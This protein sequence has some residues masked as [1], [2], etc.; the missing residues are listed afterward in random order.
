MEQDVSEES[1]SGPGQ[2]SPRA[3]VAH[4]KPQQQPHQQPPHPQHTECISL[5]GTE[6]NNNSSPCSRETAGVTGLDAVN[7]KRSHEQVIQNDLGL[8]PCADDLA[9]N[10]QRDSNASSSSSSVP[11][12]ASCLPASAEAASATTPTPA[13]LE[14]GLNRNQPSSFSDGTPA[15]EIAMPDV[16]RRPAPSILVHQ[17]TIEIPVQENH[18]LLHSPTSGG[19]GG[20]CWESSKL[21]EAS[22][23]EEADSRGLLAAFGMSDNCNG[24]GDA[25]EDE[26]SDWE[27]PVDVDLQET[28]CPAISKR[29]SKAKWTTVRAVTRLLPYSRPKHPWTQMAGHAGRFSLW[30]LRPPST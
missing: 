16:H 17:S 5:E 19:P 6:Q 29:P 28:P 26:S 11:Q 14:T 15:R 18:R 27:A 12:A 7:R 24:R 22:Q 25:T 8:L 23:E 30:I 9:G 1:V 2:H 21:A 3:V 10:R 20:Q 4:N 13:G